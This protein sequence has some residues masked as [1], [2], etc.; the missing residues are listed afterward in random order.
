MIEELRRVLLVIQGL[1]R[2]T[3]VPISIDTS[4]AIVAREAIEAGAC[5]VNDVARFK[6]DVAMATVVRKTG[7]GIVLTHS[8]PTHHDT[9]YTDVA[10]EVKTA[11][12]AALA[13]AREQGIAEAACVIDPGLGFAKDTVHNVA[14]LRKLD[15]LATLA[16]VLVGASRKRFIGELCDE[17]DP[18]ARLGGSVAVAAWSVLHGASIIRA[19]DVKETL[20]ALRVV[21]AIQTL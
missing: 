19:H 16:P 2:Q 9:R 7:A 4:H 1:A 14:L 6:D 18:K 10:E 17:N 15:V 20:E 21:D 8:R 13:Y 12:E 11:L 5:I 3:R